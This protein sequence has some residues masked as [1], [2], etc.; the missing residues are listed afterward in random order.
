[1]FASYE[2]RQPG[3][4]RPAALDGVLVRAATR[5]DAQPI[6][7]LLAEREGGNVE[8][9]REKIASE[10]GR[11]DVGEKRLLLVGEVDGRVVSFG[12]VVYLVPAPDAP[13]NA[14]PEGWYLG[15]VVVAAAYRRRGLGRELTRRRLDWLR[16]RG[17]D[18]AWYFVNADNRASI[19]LHAAFG[20][21]EMTR[22]FVRPGV[23]F[24]GRGVG[25]LYRAELDAVPAGFSG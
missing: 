18:A 5:E 23:T 8:T 14:A 22:D 2:P 10:L 6:A 11:S 7:L 25:I 16:E 24:S 15:G 20:F 4:Q 13:A 19:D 17:V 3:R 1:M 9:H 12:R 21:R